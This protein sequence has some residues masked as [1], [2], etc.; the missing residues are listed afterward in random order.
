[1]DRNASTSVI[2]ELGAEQ[3]FPVHLCEIYFDNERIFLTDAYR[4]ISW[5]GNDYISMGHLLGFG[6]IEETHELVVSNM[7]VSLSGVDQRYFSTFLSVSYV[8]RQITSYKS[9]LNVNTEV[10]V[11][12]PILIFDGRMDQ[13]V[14]AEDPDAGTSVVTVNCTNAWVDFERRPGRKTNYEEQQIW[15]PGDKGFEFA[16]EITKEIK[17]GI[18]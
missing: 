5:D 1:M 12:D 9:F 7:T 4:Q 14:I 13:P 16:S 2:T 15:F 6:D 18:A 8:D 17:W 11:T 10:L 3:N